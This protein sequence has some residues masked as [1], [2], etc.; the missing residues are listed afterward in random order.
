[1]K[2]FAYVNPMNEKEAVAALSARFEQALPIGGGQ[3]LLA[4]MKDYVTQP[5]RIVQQ[6]LGLWIGCGGHYSLSHAVQ[7]RSN[8]A[9]LR[10]SSQGIKKGRS[11][12][13]TIAVQR[14]NSDT[15][16]LLQSNTRRFSRQ[17]RYGMGQHAEIGSP[18][19]GTDGLPRAGS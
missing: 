1:M 14:S 16:A 10:S 18:G 7:K 9:D 8:R 11:R 6:A 15:E 19:I 2:A 13:R 5:E 4:R 3:D 17:Y 12:P